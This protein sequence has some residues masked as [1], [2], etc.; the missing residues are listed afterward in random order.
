M[1]SKR[2]QQLGDTSIL[3]T[4]TNEKYYAPNETELIDLLNEQEETIEEL[5]ISDHMGWKRAEHFEKEL[6]QKKI[7]IKRL[8]YKVQ[9]FKEMN[10]EQQATINELQGQI[11]RLNYII[12]ELRKNNYNKFE[13]INKMKKEEKLYAEEIVRLNNEI[14]ELRE[15]NK[16]WL[17]FKE[18]GGDY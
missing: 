1:M 13:L 16:E 14:G 15:T 4:Q 5:H 8:E 18:L 9:K 10:S 6:K 3:D 17:E 7:Y 11:N 12:E 2:F